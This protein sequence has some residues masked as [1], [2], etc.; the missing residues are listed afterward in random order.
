M[1]LP[2]GHKQERTRMLV[3]EIFESLSSVQPF[4]VLGVS[5]NEY[6]AAEFTSNGRKI[7]FVASKEDGVWNVEFAEMVKAVRSEFGDT[8]NHYTFKKTGSG[9]EFEV[10]ATIK[11]IVA[12]FVKEYKPEVF[13][14]TSDKSDKSRSRLYKTL[15]QKFVPPNYELVINPTLEPL[16]LE[17]EFDRDVV[18]AFIKKGTYLLKAVQKNN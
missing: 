4:K 12:Q 3:N 18:F 6:F 11:A 5:D 10:F 8:V 16:G 1:R 13:Y 15:S 2:R 17:Y 7:K 9:N 14:F